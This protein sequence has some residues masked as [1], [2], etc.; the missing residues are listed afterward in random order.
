MNKCIGCKNPTNGRKK[1]CIDCDKEV[2]SLKVMY[3][4][5]EKN[6]RLLESTIPQKIK[7]MREKYKKRM[8]ELK[9]KIKEYENGKI[10]RG[11]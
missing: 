11:E 9:S 1:R 8:S 4:L 5:A 10:H 7:R 2:K 6:N 3:R